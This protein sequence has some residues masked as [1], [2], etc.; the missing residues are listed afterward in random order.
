[1]RPIIA[2]LCA[3]AILAPSPV[4]ADEGRWVD[5]GPFNGTFDCESSPSR[6]PPLAEPGTRRARH[7]VRADQ[8]GTSGERSVAQFLRSTWDRVAELRGR[9]HL[10]G[11]DPGRVTLAQVLRQSIW[12]RRNVGA[13]QWTCNRVFGRFADGTGPQYVTAEHRLPRDPDRCARNLRRKWGRSKTVA[14]SVCGVVN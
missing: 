1:M 3:V 13:D 8:T 6:K 10:I 11:K 7:E 12:L 9:P 4:W 14:E 2:L 5:F